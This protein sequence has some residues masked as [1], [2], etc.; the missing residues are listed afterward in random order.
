MSDSK[1]PTNVD[2]PDYCPQDESVD[3]DRFIAEFPDCFMN[4]EIALQQ[5]M[6][7]THDAFFYYLFRMPNFSIA[8]FKQILPKKLLESLE[9]EKL[10]VLGR[11]Y[12]SNKLV[13]RSPDIVYSIPVRREVCNTGRTVQTDDQ[14]NSEEEEITDYL[15]IRIIME[16]KP[17]DDYY[18]I[19]QLGYYS[20]EENVENVEKLSSHRYLGKKVRIPPTLAVLF[21]HGLKKYSG[22]YEMREIYV[23]I[24]GMEEY[25]INLK[26]L[27]Y[28]LFEISY[29]DIP[30]DEN[31]PELEVG[32]T[33]LKAVFDPNVGMRTEKVFEKLR[34]YMHL[35]AYKKF[36]FF[37][38]CYLSARATHLTRQ[39]ATKLNEMFYPLMERSVVMPGLLERCI[40]EGREEGEAKGVKNSI[41]VILQ[42]RFV[43]VSDE[44]IEKLNAINDLDQ[45]KSLQRISIRC[46]SLWDFEQDL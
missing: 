24:P 9:I 33:L 13:K 39:E 35:A 30:K 23:I 42:E 11:V 12:L 15:Q 31:V 1:Q 38:L 25:G 40:A 2:K 26:P 34:P 21:I 5:V 45:L 18:G 20:M 44:I 37:S 46:S 14:M 43:N 19:I 22:P 32:L 4:V 28:D 16:A 17:D 27:I 10:K 3:L 36:V 6:K 41:I 8:F 7:V 29:E